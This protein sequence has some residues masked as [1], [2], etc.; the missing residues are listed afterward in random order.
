M[1]RSPS[2]FPFSILTGAL[3]FEVKNLF[4][5]MPLRRDKALSPGQAGSVGPSWTCL[6][7]T[8]SFSLSSGDPNRSQQV[9]GGHLQGDFLPLHFLDLFLKDL[10][11]VYYP[12]T[13]VGSIKNTPEIL[14]LPQTVFRARG[15][16]ECSLY[17]VPA[18]PS[19]SQREGTGSSGTISDSCEAPRGCWKLNSGPLQE[20]PVLLTTKLSLQ[21]SWPKF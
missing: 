10:F 2:Q 8:G 9:S 6:F 19:E 16:P 12:D 4:R 17:D 15:W 5:E 14:L 1:W 13:N 11:L 20:Q 7:P 18:M 3:Y 21:P